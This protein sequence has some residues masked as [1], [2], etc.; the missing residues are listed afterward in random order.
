[1]RAEAAH[2][3]AVVVYLH[4]G[5]ELAV[6]PTARQRQLAT[7]L[8][9]AGADLVVGSH[10]HV[11]QPGERLGHT[12]VDYGLGNFVFYAHTPATQRTGVLTVEVG[13]D[14]VHSTRWQPATIQDGL[15][16]LDRSQA[17][18]QALRLRAQ[19]HC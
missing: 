2:A 11:P 5:Q 13:T 8:A 14:G 7:L 19:P 1:V 18:A 15:P 12:Y 16:V 9:T 10:A 17:K 3:D 6:C 4:W